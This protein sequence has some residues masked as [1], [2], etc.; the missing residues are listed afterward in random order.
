MPDNNV[1]YGIFFSGEV[2][3]GQS[4]DAVKARMATL[5]RLSDHSRLDQRISDR[6]KLE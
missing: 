1:E 2:Q 5:F 4:V 6:N 3:A